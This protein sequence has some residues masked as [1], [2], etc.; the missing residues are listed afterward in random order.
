[1][2]FIFTDRFKRS[3]KQLPK[4]VQK[5]LQKEL[6]LMSKDPHHPSLR[7]KKIQGTDKL[8]VCRINM[9]IRLTWQCQGEA[10]LLRVM[11]PHDQVLDNP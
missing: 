11:G 3:Y 5:V 4:D 7:T 1:M 8:F 6:E 9:S 10:I 2:E